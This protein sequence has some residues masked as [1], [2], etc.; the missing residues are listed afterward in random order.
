MMCNYRLCLGP[1]NTNFVWKQASTQQLMQIITLGQGY[2]ALRSGRALCTGNWRGVLVTTISSHLIWSCVVLSTIHSHSIRD[3][4]WYQLLVVTWSEDVW[5]SQVFL[6]TESSRR[7]TWKVD[8]HGSCNIPFTSSHLLHAICAFAIQ[9]RLATHRSP[10]TA[11]CLVLLFIPCYLLPNSWCCHISSSTHTSLGVA[12]Q[13]LLLHPPQLAS[14]SL[15]LQFSQPLNIFYLVLP[16]IPCH[17]LPTAVCWHL[18]S[19]LT[20]AACCHFPP[21]LTT[22]CLVLPLAT[23]HVAKVATCYVNCYLSLLWLLH[24]CLLCPYLA[25]SCQNILERHQGSFFLFY[26][27]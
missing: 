2:R 17:S 7:L 16:Q 9:L 5:W 6:V 24:T 8:V 25:C 20:P 27:I 18:S 21:A 23:P 26:L 14:Y 1:G 22:C 15:V 4:W 3:V 10:L 12:T 13:Y 11:F 19:A